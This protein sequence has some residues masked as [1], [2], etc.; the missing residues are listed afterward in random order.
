MKAL[1]INGSPHRQGCTNLALEYVAKGLAEGGVDAQIVWLGSKPL[2]GCMACNACRKT[3]RRIHD[4]VVNELIPLANEADGIVIGS[5]VHYAAASGQVTSAMHRLFY[6][7][8]VDWSGKVGAS[9][10][11]CRRGGA[12]AAFD[13]LNKYFTITGMPIVSSYY[14]TQIH[15]NTPEEAMRDEEGLATMQQLGLNMAWLIRCIK[16]GRDAGF[17]YPGRVHS[18]KTNFIR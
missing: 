16:A 7:G 12:S 6:T 2:A 17:A 18:A 15:G 4:D 5:P 10:V 9:V 1:L 8:A 11:S 3:G 14:W 13:Q